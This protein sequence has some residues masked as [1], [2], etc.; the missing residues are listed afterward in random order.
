MSPVIRPVI[1]RDQIQ[2]RLRELADQ[3]NK[4]YAGEELVLIG[5]LKG[6]F[7]FLADLVRLLNMPIRV[8]FVRVR[9]YGT[10]STS[11][12]T[13]EITKDVEL[14]LRHRHVLVVED[15]IDSGLTLEYLLRHLQKQQPKSLKICCLTDKLERR[16]LLVPIDY[17]GFVVEKGFLVG[18]GLDYAEDYRQYPDICE[19]EL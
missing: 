16:S 6:V 19:L 11:S 9:S 8:D 13:V 15:I 12:G 2:A 10:A 17:V 3:I 5:V 1:T 18:Y 7:I 14:D 4:D